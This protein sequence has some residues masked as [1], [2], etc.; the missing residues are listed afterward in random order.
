MINLVLC[1]ILQE[2]I[3]L[4]IIVTITATLRRSR[5]ITL[6]MEIATNHKLPLAEKR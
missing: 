2:I 1:E 6:Q 3:N 5:Y 4:N